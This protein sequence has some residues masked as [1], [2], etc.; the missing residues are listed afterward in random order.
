MK[1]LVPTPPAYTQQP[2]V[3]LPNFN[4]EQLTK[5]AIEGVSAKNRCSWM[6]CR[7]LDESRKNLDTDFFGYFEKYLVVAEDGK[8][9]IY[10]FMKWC[11]ECAVN[12]K[13]LTPPSTVTTL[14][15]RVTY[16]CL[17]DPTRKAMDKA[18]DKTGYR[19]VAV[20]D[21]AK[22]LAEEAEA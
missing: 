20:S 5:E 12:T 17:S 13:T 7:H 22:K 1:L 16:M 3:P 15:A 21:R 18:M 8:T 10:V 9:T 2:A 4:T 19:V 6:E 11:H 14:V